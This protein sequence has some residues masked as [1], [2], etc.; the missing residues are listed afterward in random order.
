M[1]AVTCF[2]IGFVHSSWPAPK[3]DAESC[4]SNRIYISTS[5]KLGF[6]GTFLNKIMDIVWSISRMSS[7]RY[8]RGC[9]ARGCSL[10]SNHHPFQSRSIFMFL[11]FFSPPKTPNAI[12]LS[13][14]LFWAVL[15][16]FPSLSF[17]TFS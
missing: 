9:T 11:P 1:E 7:R 4:Y 3:I 16:Y 15:N 8:L 12:N 2:P 5:A 13:K 10:G 17:K 6:F 14:T